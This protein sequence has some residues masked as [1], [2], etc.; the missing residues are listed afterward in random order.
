VV[1]VDNYLDGFLYLEDIKENIEEII[2]SLI[3]N[4]TRL[5]NDDSTIRK[6]SE[7]VWQVEGISTDYSDLV[8]AEL[9]PDE[10]YKG[11]RYNQQVFCGR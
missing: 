7:N 11:F 6:L 2:H 10:G 5:R 3:Q 1:Y 8:I 4:E 9:Y